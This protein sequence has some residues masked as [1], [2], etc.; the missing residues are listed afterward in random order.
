MTTLRLGMAAI[1]LLLVSRPRIAGWTRAQWRSVATFG[2]IMA[3]MNGSFYLSIERL[4]LS[5]AVAIEFVGPLVLSAV[6]SRRAIDLA[7]VSLAVVGIG[8]LG[9][10]SLTQTGS[11]DPLGVLFAVIAGSFW[12]LYIVSSAHVGQRVPGTGGLAIALAFATVVV[13]P[14]GMSGLTVAFEQPLLLLPTLGVA[15]LC[16]AIP[17]TLEL[18]A[19]RRLPRSVFG[20]LLSL[21]P[22]IAVLSGWILLGQSTGRLRLAAIA[23]VITASI[24]TIVT[25]PK[26]PRG[27]QPPL[28]PAYSPQRLQERGVGGESTDHVRPQDVVG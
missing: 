27:T 12:A 1:L 21:E 18:A 24:G 10:E 11:L 22:I 4:P 13:A 17:Y 7:W 19:L 3:G 16:S 8:L 9:V 28:E 20:I 15:L 26:I 14:L 23:L 2:V 5:A 25:T 6:L